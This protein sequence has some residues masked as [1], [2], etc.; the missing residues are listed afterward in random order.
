VIAAD[1]S[2][3]VAYFAGYDG[4][5]VERIHSALQTG[6]LRISPV[7]F[8]ELLSDPKTTVELEKTVAEW[9]QLAIVEGYWL[10]AARTRAHLLSLK[11]KPKLPDTLI[12]QAAID[13]DL[14]LIARDEGFRHFAKYCGLKLA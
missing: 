4:H 6:E 12:A 10:R 1:T 2:S 8:T 3:L 11:L 14:P 5:D 13:H 9:R 7:V